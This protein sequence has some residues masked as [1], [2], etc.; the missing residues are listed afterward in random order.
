MSRPQNELDVDEDSGVTSL[1]PVANKPARFFEL[2]EGD[3]TSYF[4]ASELLERG[5]ALAA[6][7]AESSPPPA[8]NAVPEPEPEAEPTPAPERQ[9]LVGEFRRAS[10]A[11]KASAV[12]LPLLC[13]VWLA[14]PPFKRSEPRVVS[15][16]NQSVAAPS[17][18]ALAKTIV[19]PVASVTPDAP[20]P[21]LPR[22][23]TAA[24]A[25]ADSVATGDF[26]RALALYRE[27]SRREPKNP[28]YREAARILG[29]R[30]QT[31]A[32]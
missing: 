27:L 30:A 17:A 13:V 16:P 4:S 28:A 6:R 25:A 22:G 24:H 11:R 5:K 2:S 7:T 26:N 3:S 18:S 32:P 15:K 20:P 31:R 23:V 14:K 12:L 19:P 29:E 9:G 10:F 8:V 1:L 21:V